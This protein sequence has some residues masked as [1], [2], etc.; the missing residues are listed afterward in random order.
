MI[1]N[2]AIFSVNKP[3]KS[4]QQTTSK[5]WQRLRWDSPASILSPMRYPIEYSQLLSYR[6]YLYTT[7]SE[8]KKSTKSFVLSTFPD[9]KSRG[10]SS[11]T[12]QDPHHAQ[13]KPSIRKALEVTLGAIT[14]RFTSRV[15][16]HQE[17]EGY[18]MM[19]DVP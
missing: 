8:K 14:G 5:P 6:Y 17:W 3:W 11:Q 13:R 2:I 10:P 12:S 19:I 7:S 16:S 18:H 4:H 1:S 15:N 9:K